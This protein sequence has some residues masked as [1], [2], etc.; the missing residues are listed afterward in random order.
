LRF[1]YDDGRVAEAETIRRTRINLLGRR[2]L[3][4]RE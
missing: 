1:R 2:S 3:E 4:A